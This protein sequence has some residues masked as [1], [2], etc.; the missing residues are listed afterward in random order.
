MST[1]TAAFL[2]TAFA[3]LGAPRPFYDTECHTSW[4][5]DGVSEYCYL[6]N[7]NYCAYGDGVGTLCKEDSAC[8]WLG[9]GSSARKM[10][11][12]TGFQRRADNTY[13][14]PAPNPNDVTDHYIITGT[15][16]DPWENHWDNHHDHRVYGRRLENLEDVEAAIQ[17][18]EGNL[19]VQEATTEQRRAEET[20][21]APRPNPNTN[22]G[23]WT[24]PGCNDSWD[25]QGDSVYC[26]KGYFRNWC[27]PGNGIGSI[28]QSDSSCGWVGFGDNAR[29]LTCSRGDM[30]RIGG[31]VGSPRPRPGSS[32]GTCVMWNGY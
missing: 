23:Q 3:Q 27:F 1:L 19:E 18:V 25:C 5:C 8:G 28:C 21:G 14:S 16:Q 24:L 17:M 22:H 2:S 12:A 6:G 32:A 11:C 15:C 13:G 7:P 20:L 30:R 31:V 4:D 29:K 9:H 26:Y 10:Y